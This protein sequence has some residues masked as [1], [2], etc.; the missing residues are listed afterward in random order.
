MET[1]TLEPP[2]FVRFSLF[3]IFEHFKSLIHL[4]LTV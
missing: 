3:L 1:P 2:I 4:V